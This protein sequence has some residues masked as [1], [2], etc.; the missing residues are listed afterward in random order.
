MHTT[1]KGDTQ[2]IKCTVLL[3]V[4]YFTWSLSSKENHHLTASVQMLGKVLE[5]KKLLREEIK[6]GAMLAWPAIYLRSQIQ[7]K[8]YGMAILFWELV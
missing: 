7:E 4:K 6:Q 3:F 1:K 2:I 8:W 5:K